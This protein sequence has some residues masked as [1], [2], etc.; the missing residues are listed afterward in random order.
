MALCSI[1]IKIKIKITR[2]R[3]RRRIWQILNECNFALR[4]P[5]S[6]VCGICALD[7]CNAWQEH[8]SLETFGAHKIA[9]GE[10]KKSQRNELSLAAANTKMLRNHQIVVECQGINARKMSEI[11]GSLRASGV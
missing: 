5:C 1:K 9:T 6:K 8:R 10:G 4:R 7:N 11:E 2:T 3:T